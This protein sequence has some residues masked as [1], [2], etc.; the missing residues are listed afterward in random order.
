[1]AVVTDIGHELLWVP[2]NCIVSRK[3]YWSYI[4]MVFGILVVEW[5]LAFWSYKLYLPS[6]Y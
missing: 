6:S 3:M 5:C 2:E 1:M 4:I